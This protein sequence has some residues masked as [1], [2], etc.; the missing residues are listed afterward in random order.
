M[1]IY[2]RDK[3]L[4]EKNSKMETSTFRG[5][6]HPHDAKELTRDRAISVLE[7]PARLV[8]PMSQH[9]GAP[10]RPCVAPGDQVL[11]GQ[12]I[13][14]PGGFVSAAVHSPVSGKVAAVEM[15]PHPLGRR[16]QSVIIENDGRNDWI[17]SKSYPDRYLDLDGQEILDIIRESGIVGMGGATFPTHVK[18]SP[19]PGKEINTVIVNAAECEPY[20]TSDYRLMMER[21]DDVL[22]GLKLVM[23]VLKVG[24]AVIGIEDN[25]PGAIRTMK[26]ATADQTGISVLALETKYPQGAELQLITAATGK[27]VPSGGLPMEVGVVVVNVGTCFAILEAVKRGRPLVDRIVTVT[28]YGVKEPKN[29]RVSVGTPFSYVFE[30]CGGFADQPGKVIM[31]GPMMGMAQFDLDVPVIKGASGILVLPREVIMDYEP[32]A[33]IRC[34]KCVDHCPMFLM[35]QNLSLIVEYGNSLDTEA[36]GVFDCKECG[37]CAFICPAKRPIVHQ[38]KFAKAEIMAEK[39]RK[40]AEDAA[41]SEAAENKDGGQEAE[42]GKE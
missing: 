19:P 34:A 24:D 39:A 38:I 42:G 21:P 16:M 1:E 36:Q 32:S 17:K 25:K 29:L 9:I 40:K 12:K 33:C 41:K 7:P 30:H 20:L 11:A 26:Q 8:I 14:E 18:L 4:W 15:A 13:G 27:E 3:H 6:L 5:G 28:G 31:G 35:P 37:C 2:D 23:R 22:D 10:A